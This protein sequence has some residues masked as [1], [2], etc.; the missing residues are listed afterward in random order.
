LRNLLIETALAGLVGGGILLMGNLSIRLL[1]AL[2]VFCAH[3]TLNGVPRSIR[4]Q[5]KPYEN[6]FLL[7]QNPRPEMDLSIVI[8]NYNTKDLLRSCLESVYNQTSRVIFEVIVVDN[9]SSDGSRE[10]IMEQFP[11]TKTVFNSENRGFAAANNQGFSV[12]LGEYV[13][14]LNSDTIVLDGALEKIVLFM[15]SNPQASIVGCKLYNA[16]GTLQPSVRSFPSLW[17]VFVESSFLYLLFPRSR[18]FGKYYMSFFDFDAECEVDWVSGAC[19]TCRKDLLKLLDGLDERFFMYS[20][21]TDFCFR[22]KQ[23]GF[24][25]WF[26]PHARVIHVRF[27]SASDNVQRVQSVTLSQLMFFVKHFTGVRR[28]GLISLNLLGIA[29]RMIGFY[30]WG[31]LSMSPPS[32]HRS[33]GH[34]HSLCGA[35]RYLIALMSGN[36][37]HR[38]ASR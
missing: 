11:A 27:G 3:F 37:G 25:T 15:R 8:V 12:A 32:L 19:L 28:V 34:F 14:M 9:A 20:E 35:T 22:A 5:R 10:M 29:V 18:T 7:S 2:I 17:N 16:D 33:R 36:Q 31:L 23:R 13:V 30:V 24:H 21:E 38:F 1:V 4:K 26:F 6:S